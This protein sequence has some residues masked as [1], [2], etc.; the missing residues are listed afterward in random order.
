MKENRNTSS[1]WSTTN[2]WKIL[3]NCQHVDY[4]FHTY[5]FSSRNCSYHEQPTLPFPF[6]I[7]AWSETPHWTTPSTTF[8]SL[9]SSFEPLFTQSTMQ[10]SCFG[11]RLLDPNRQRSKPQTT[12][13]WPPTFTFIQNGRHGIKREPHLCFQWWWHILRG[14]WGRGALLQFSFIVPF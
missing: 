13:Q 1:F 2:I 12:P 3:L 14:M 4:Y 8:S 6:S 5:A 7:L 10:M 9:W 11:K